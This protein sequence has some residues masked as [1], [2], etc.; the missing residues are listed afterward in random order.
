MRHFTY[1]LHREDALRQTH[2]LQTEIQAERD[3]LKSLINAL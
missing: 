3:A 1:I 2:Q